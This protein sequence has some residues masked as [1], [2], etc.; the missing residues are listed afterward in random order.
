MTIKGKQFA[1][2][3]FTALLASL[4]AACV[5]VVPAPANTNSNTNSNSA[6][7]STTPC[8]IEGKQELDLS[9]GTTKTRVTQS[10]QET[11]IYIENQHKVHPKRCRVLIGTQ[12][13][14]LYIMPGDNR[15][16]SHTGA[17]AQSTVQVGCVNDWNRTR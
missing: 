8:N 10:C 15:T 14:E 6:Q 2:L 12:A 9:D 17:V 3:G 5:A 11:V 7:N 13:T 4:T 1:R 16:L